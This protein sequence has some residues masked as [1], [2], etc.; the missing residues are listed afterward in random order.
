MVTFMKANFIEE[1]VRVAGFITITWMGDMRVIGLMGSMMAMELRHGLKGADIGANTGRVYGM[2]LGF[3]GFIQVTFILVS[4]QMGTVT[5][6]VFI[7]VRMVVSTLGSSSGV[8][9]MGLVIT[10]SGE[11]LIFCLFFFWIRLNDG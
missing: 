11:V 7:L 8:L 2:G 3:I 4:G 9:S 10:I 5:V 1:G 6:V